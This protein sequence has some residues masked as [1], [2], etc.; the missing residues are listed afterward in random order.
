CCKSPA[1]CASACASRSSVSRALTRGPSAPRLLGSERFFG[2]SGERREPLLVV[3]GDVGK[4]L[5]IDLDLGAPETVHEPAVGQPVCARGRVDPRDPQRA[6]LALALT[7][8]AIRV[9]AGLDD[10]LLRDP[11]NPAPRPV[12]TLR[13][14]EHLAVAGLRDDASFDSGH[15]APPSCTAASCARPARP[16][17]PPARSDEAAAYAS[18]TSS[19]GCDSSETARA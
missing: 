15:P 10:R 13:L 1:A 16:A 19:S 14:V 17:G 12:V 6:E 8:V 5:A 11:V 18:A 3:D 4:N 2:R 7:A 9:L